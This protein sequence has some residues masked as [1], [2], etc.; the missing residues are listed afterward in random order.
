MNILLNYLED[1]HTEKEKPKENKDPGPVIT[2][3]RQIG[4]SGKF[5]AD[6]LA[7]TLNKKLH[8]QNGPWRVISKEIL[9]KSAKELELD[10]SQIE[11]VFK[12]EK[13]SAIDDILGAL[14]S[15]YYKSDRKIRN[16]I[17]KVI[18]S[19]GKEGHSIILG[20]CGSSI[21]KNINRS[22][23]IRLIAP[24]DWR[25]QVIKK[26][27]NLTTKK[28]KDYVVDIDKKRQELR[29]NLAGSKIDDTHYDLLINAKHFNHDEIADIILE[30]M[31]IKGL[32]S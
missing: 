32:Y 26:R 22:L 29:N 18:Y 9:E 4:C 13:K 17:K 23:H 2:I 28:A 1:R 5:L 20:R 25:V 21:T 6:K 30:T 7:D 15:K 31:S 8:Q 3:S 27:F 12:Y 16:T 11:Y 24:F 14:S 10:P 19:F